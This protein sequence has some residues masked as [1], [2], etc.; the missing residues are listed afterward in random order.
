MK[1]RMKISLIL[2]LAFCLQT[3]LGQQRQAPDFKPAAITSGTLDNGLQYYIMHNE[4]PKDRVSFYFAQ[5]VGSILEEDS[6]Q[7]LAHFLEH[8]AF[9]G[10]EHFQDKQML[11]YLEKNGMQFGSEINAFTSFDETVYNINKVP[12]QNDKLLDSVFMVLYDWSGG[13]T[14][15]EEEIDNE[16]GVVR[17]EWRSRNTPMNRATD[18]IFKQGIL[19]GSKYENRFPIGLMEV[20]DNFEYDA[21]RDYYRRWYRPDQQAIVVVGDIDPQEMEQKI[22]KQFAKIPLR[23]DLPKRGTF[24]I[25]QGEDFTYITATDKELG[26]PTIQYY[27][28]HRADTT[29]NETEDLQSSL[30]LQIGS[31]ILNNR[32]SEISREQDS[33]VL[34]SNFGLSNFVRPLDILSM[35]AQ[36]KKDS[37]LASVRF[38]LLELK[39]FMVHGATDTELSR[40]KA[41]FKTSFE[42]ALKNIDKRQ[43]DSYAGEIFTAF[44]KNKRVGDYQW[45]LKYRLAYLEKIQQ[46]DLRTHFN[47][48]YS[49]KENVIAFI[50]SDSIEY[51]SEK[52]VIAVMKE[53]METTPE[54]FTEEVSDKQLIEEDLAGSAIVSRNALEGL[55]AET[56]TLAN[57][58]RVTLYPTTY[59]KE[60]VFFQAYSPGGKSLI[61]KELLSN[62]MVATTLAGESGI[63]NMDK[64]ELNK[65][66]QGKQT[67]LSVEIGEYAE[68]L[69]GSSTWNDVET[70]MKR[71]YLAFTKPR[72][73]DNAF[74]I[75]KQSFEN[76]LTAK[77]NNVKSDFQDSL[78]LAKSN[79]SSR[80]LLFNKQLI[81]ELSPEKME[82]VYT[83]RIRNAADFDFV[84]VG[85]FEKEK[86]LEM[87]QVY[88]GS[89]PGDQARDSVVNHHMKPAEGLSKVH[90]ARKMETPQTTINILLTGTLEYNKKNNLILNVIG[91]LLNKRYLERIREAE[92]GSYGV[93]A[94]GYMQNIPEDSYGLSISFNCNPDKTDRLIAIVFEEIKNL[95]H[96]L[97]AEE[98]YEIKSNLKKGVVENRENNSYWLRS[99]TNSIKNNTSLSTEEE[100]LERIDAITEEE[101]KALATRINKNPRIVEGVLTPVME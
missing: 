99:I 9:N 13:L 10:T 21:L 25:P 83:S 55:E 94:Y 73:D 28:K 18:K 20:V 76:A 81:E 92:G 95:T 77:K 41:A 75:L 6:Q 62:A 100:V 52:Q 11:E 14:L 45:N 48:Y 26:E 57:G 32:L 44:F 27:I 22:K 24:E 5:N 97:D 53:V 17:E 43:S 16:R 101:I 31:Y 8:M 56:I 69:G 51:P 42:A 72:F 38:S 89:I 30:L 85:D 39:R 58:A 84:F 66:L 50:G 35:S 19:K 34:S 71:I 82:A 2:L 90:M 3:A 68:A 86:L 23:D 67:S 60:Q 65:H 59:D 46:E 79:Y 87:I 40:A 47:K 96:Q 78:Q 36:P 15:L 91:Q 29:L 74:E 88:I 70:M 7:G 1:I 4:E 54:A 98:L 80:D 63:G 61:D 12:V 64:I 33:P 49:P 37:L 93:Q